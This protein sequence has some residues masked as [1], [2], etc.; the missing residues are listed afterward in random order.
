MKKLTDAGRRMLRSIEDSGDPT[1]H[2][3]GMSEYGGATA[4]IRYLQRNGLVNVPTGRSDK[5]RLTEKGKQ[6]L[7][8][9]HSS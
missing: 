9:T 7:K 4:T 5:W 3:E 6:L 1:Q 8:A 2:C